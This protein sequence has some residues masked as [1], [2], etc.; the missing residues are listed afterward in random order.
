MAMARTLLRAVLLIFAASGSLA[1]DAPR[2]ERLAVH[3]VKLE[4]EGQ[5]AN[6]FAELTADAELTPPEAGSAPRN[7]PMFWDG[8]AAWKFRFSP[9][10]VGTWQ[11]SVKSPDA[12]LNGKSGSFEV[13]ASRR[14][15]SIRPMKDFPRH[16][17]RQN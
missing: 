4:A 13:V 6:P 11:W 15:G 17:E 3:E 5:Y 14:P 8:G 12:G 7:V 1:A 16:F 2:V 9:E 10:Q